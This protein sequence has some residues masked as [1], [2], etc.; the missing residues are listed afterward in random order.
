MTRRIALVA[1]AITIAAA[2]LAAQSARAQGAPAAPTKPT[3]VLASVQ[4]VWQMTN[5]NGQDLA[6]SGQEMLITIKD[7]TYVQTVN[8]QMIERGTFKIDE[9]KKPMTIDISIVE[10]DDA[11]KTQLG[12]FE[13]TGNTMKGKLGDPGTARPADFTVAEG[14]FVFVMT[15]K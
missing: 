3:G 5:A 8:G 12:V 6:G 9:S 7:N 14:Y 4:G 10:G 11:G 15:K 13:L 2:P 1:L